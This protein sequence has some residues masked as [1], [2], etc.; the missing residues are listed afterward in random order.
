VLWDVD[1]TLI[2]AGGVG[3]RLYE[4]AL[5]D[6]YGLDL[7]R[8]AESF[9]GRTDS[10]IV[11][12]MLR[13]AGVPDPA[14]QVR[15]F[16]AYLAA[17]VAQTADE[18]RERGRVLP[19]AAQALA[20]LAAPDHHGR[21]VQSLLTGNIPEFAQ[22]KITTLG[23]AEHLD[24]TIGAYGDISAI[25]A[26]LVGV[27]RAN[28]AARH[29][30]DFAG[31]A[32]VL[33]G[34]TPSDVEAALMTGASAVGVATGEFSVAELAAAGAHAVLPDLADTQATVAAILSAGRGELLLGGH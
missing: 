15:P 1:F 20:A 27:A 14:E 32:T 3:R 8:P 6:M 29:G 17:R 34:D 22:V 24:L 10:A 21:V 9:A 5:R 12:E 28:A 2:D 31:R 7:R 11:F 23:L 33:V 18:L 26:D 13:L 4:V 19:G 30:L 25:R 16:Q